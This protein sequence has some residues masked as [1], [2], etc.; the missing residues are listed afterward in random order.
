MGQYN[1]GQR[2]TPDEARMAIE[3]FRFR[4]YTRSGMLIDDSV[5]AGNV[6]E[7]IFYGNAVYDCNDADT[8]TATVTSLIKDM[9]DDAPP[10]LVW[11]R[12]ESW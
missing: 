12:P 4:A 8:V 2:L 3:E 9:G 5:F 7:V 10:G 1:N 6:D 11:K